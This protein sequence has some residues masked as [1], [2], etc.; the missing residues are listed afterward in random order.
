[1][2]NRRL[3]WLVYTIMERIVPYYIRKYRHKVE[4]TD[5]ADINRD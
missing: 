3:D 2:A 4:E 5:E 1:M